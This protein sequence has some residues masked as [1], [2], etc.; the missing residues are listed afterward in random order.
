LLRFLSQR[1]RCDE[2]AQDILQETLIRYAQYSQ[3]NQVDNARAFIYRVAANL[4][5]DY[6][7]SHARHAYADITPEAIAET[8]ID[9]APLPDQCAISDQQLEIL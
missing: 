5:T 9:P 4:A 2:D 6:L 7:R 8:V 3:T 1:V